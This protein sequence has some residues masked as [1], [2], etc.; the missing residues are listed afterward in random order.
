MAGRRHADGRERGQTLVEFSLAL[1]PFLFLLMGI[2]DLGRG[3]HTNN[4][5]SHAARE[6]ARAASVHPC[7]G[8][9]AAGTLSTRVRDTI[10]A[11]RALVPGLSDDDIVIECT[12]VTD[13][14][15]TVGAASQCPPGEYIRV[16]VSTDFR[17]VTPFLPVPNPFTVS[18]TAHVQVP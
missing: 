18:A 11:Q 16:T 14:V 2:V 8:P 10:A 1:M 4:G 5:V 15:R 6:I 3:I 7:A 9:C 13:T 12:D 17:L